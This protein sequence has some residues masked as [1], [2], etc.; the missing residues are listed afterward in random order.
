M[1][2]HI[3]TC[4]Y[5]IRK[6]SWNRGKSASAAESNHAI[7]FSLLYKVYNKQESKYTKDS[8]TKFLGDILK[9]D[10]STFP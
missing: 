8:Q 5:C 6:S 7:H 4:E 3:I 1:Q 10:T 2:L 9:N